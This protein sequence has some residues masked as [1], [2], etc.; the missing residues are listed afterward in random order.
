MRLG[1]AILKIIFYLIIVLAFVAILIQIFL[2]VA[3]ILFGSKAINLRNDHI[4]KTKI[5]CIFEDCNIT[6]NDNNN[7]I[8]QL[9]VDDTSKVD[10]QID[11][12]KIRRIYIKNEAI[13]LQTEYD[14]MRILNSRIKKLGGWRGFEIKDV[15]LKH[16]Y[17]DNNKEFTFATH[18]I[19]G[20]VCNNKKLNPKANSR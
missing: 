19:N 17:V 7:Y 16:F 5:I 10:V 20:Q 11:K 18:V 4:S 6:I 1:I 3:N 15:N 8:I 13:K 14:S 2:L 9:H 12:N